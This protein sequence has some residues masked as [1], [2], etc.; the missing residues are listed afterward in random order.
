MQ[1]IRA[2]V[3]VGVLAAAALAATPMTASARSAARARRAARCSVRTSR[4][5]PSAGPPA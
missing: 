3:T 5:N 1:K 4:P 2:L